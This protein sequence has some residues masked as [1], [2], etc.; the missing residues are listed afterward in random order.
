MAANSLPL[1]S[2]LVQHWLPRHGSASES[3]DYV[4]LAGTMGFYAARSQTGAA[5]CVIQLSDVPSGAVGR[6]AAGFTL[7]AHES[8]RFQ[9]SGQEWTAPAAV[10]SCVDRNLLEVFASLTLDIAHRLDSAHRSWTSIVAV[11]EGWQALLATRPRPTRE[12][13][14]GLWGELWLLDV[15]A[16]PDGLI[17]AWRGPDGD[18]CDFFLDGNSAEVKTS[19]QRRRHH[20]S[21]A[22]VD[23]PVGDKT[24]WLL[25]LWVGIDP[26]RGRTVPVLVDGLFSRVSDS[27]QAMR[28]L[29][30]AGF[31]PA[32]RDEYQTGF[33]VLAEPEWYRISAVPRVRVADP[34]VSQLRYNVSLDEAQRLDESDA[35]R[36]WKLFLRQE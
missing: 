31:S 35:A 2:D 30:T 8:M 26:I 28:K 14:M 24:S 1:H 12:S 11:V 17:S 4:L 15:C 33:V 7:T 32:D 36:L 29:L 3:S 10:L 5:A 27:A 23:D 16:R 18:S 25:S 22:Q 21:Q 20:I 13:E 6:V 19:R 34:G 9:Y